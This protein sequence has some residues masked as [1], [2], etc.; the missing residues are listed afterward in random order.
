MAKPGSPSFCFYVLQLRFCVMLT[1]PKV[2]DSLQ[3]IRSSGKDCLHCP[4]SSHRFCNAILLDPLV[5]YM[6]S[7][8]KNFQ[9]AR[10]TSMISFL[11]PS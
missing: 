5:V 3:S 9:T 10:K 6:I 11:N 1:P 2:P 4:T 8:W 7:S